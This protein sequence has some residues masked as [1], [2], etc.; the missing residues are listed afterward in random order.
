MNSVKEQ[1]ES[2][3]KSNLDL[4]NLYKLF[5]SVSD[6]RLILRFQL[7][8]GTKVI[9]MRVN[10]R[11]KLFLN[12]DELSYPPMSCEQKFGRANIP[13]H[14]MFYGSFFAQDVFSPEPRMIV[15]TEVSNNIL[16]KTSSLVERQTYALFIVQEDLKLIAFPFIGSYDRPCSDIQKLQNQWNSIDK[17]G[18][19]YDSVELMTYMSNQIATKFSSNSD[20]P[21]LANYIY[22]LLYI[23]E[24]TKDIDG[25]IYPTVRMDGNGFNL[26]IKPKSTDTKLRFIQATECYMCKRQDY[27]TV[28]NIQDGISIDKLGSLTYS[29]NKTY[30]ESETKRFTEDLAFLN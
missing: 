22:Y 6:D 7:P 27:I 5:K 2:F 3:D 9:R 29:P 26:A 17:G 13:G 11:G 4:V 24:G 23:N 28:L 14:P 1:L 25:I 21:I 8:L 12:K 20:Y 15:L 10:E 19:S 16:D 30:D 18:I